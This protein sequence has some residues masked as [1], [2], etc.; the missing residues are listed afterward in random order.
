M[1]YKLIIYGNNM[2]KEFVL[3][4]HFKGALTFGTE[5]DCQICFQ[6]ERFL[7]DFFVQLE[8]KSDGRYWLNCSKSVC[9]KTKDGKSYYS[10]PADAGDRLSLCYMVNG[11]EFFFLDFVYAFELV[12]ADYNLAIDWS[13]SITMSVGGRNGCRVRI[14]D[15]NL[16]NDC[17]VIH[18]IDH[19]YQLDAS[20]TE[21]GISTN[22]IAIR[23]RRA[24]I[25]EGEFFSI[26]GY[27]FCLRDGILYTTK[28]AVITT[29]LPVSK[30]DNQKNYLNY[31]KFKRNVRQQYLLPDTKIEIRKPKSK[32]NSEEQNFL[33][34]FLPVLINFILMIGLRGIMGGGGVFVLY[35]AGSM[36]VS[37]TVS[38]ITYVRDKKK[39]RNAE[40]Q[41]E[42]KYLEYIDAQEQR[43]MEL[44]K[45]EK[46]IANQMHPQLD[47]Y[48]KF[49]ADFD[50]RLFEKEREHEDYLS[51]RLGSGVVPSCCQV[52]YTEEEYVET[53][54]ELTEYPRLL[55]D[56]YQYLDD[57]PVLLELKGTN[58]VG[59]IGA[60]TKLYQM[61]KNLLISYA[62]SHFYKDVKLFLIMEEEDVPMFEWARWLQNTYNDSTGTRNFMYDGESA[63]VS[64][65]FL[66]SELSSRESAG[67]VTG[68]PEYIVFVYRSDV[69]SEHPVSEYIDRAQEFG[70]HFVFFEEHE[71]LLHNACTKRIFLDSRD[72]AG[73]VQ[74]VK[75]GKEIQEFRYLHI[76]KEAA[77]AAA[78]RLACVYV[79]E[80][81]LENSL[82]KNITLFE[83][84]DILSPYD[85]DLHARW[86]S[87]K[88]YESMRAPLGVKSGGEIVYLDLHEKY[89]GPHGL[90][91]GTT[92]SGKSEIL[93]S[94]IL[95][96]ATLFPPSEVGFIIIDFK[97]GGMAN[98]FR[99]LPHLIGTITNIDGREI[100]RSLLSIKAELV[101]RQELF[102]EQNVNHIND[103]IQAYKEGKAEIALP[104][105]IL[106][107][108]EFAELKSDQPEFMKELISASRIGR[109]LG[110]HLI[111][112]T[113]K[114]AGVVSD[115]IWSNSKFKL[116]LKVQ[117]KN[118]SNEVL[119]SPLAAEIREPGR[120]YLQ[121]GNNEI[122]QLFQSAYSGARVKNDD[123]TKQRAFRITKV[124]LSGAR[125]VLYE[126]KPEED[127]QGDTQLSALVNY[128]HDY[129]EE[130]GIQKLPEICLPSL[131]D[132]LP[133][134]EEA[135]D[136]ETMEGVTD[137]V[138]PIGIVDV[139]DRQAQ[140]VET[141]DLSKNNYFI[142]G[143]SQSGKTNLLQVM[144]RGLAQSY[145]AHQVNMYIIDMA[146]MILR[147][148]DSLAHVAGVVTAG[149]ED[150]LKRLLSMLEEEISNR[151]RLLSEYGLSSYSAYRE[152]GKTDLPQIVVFLDNWNG[153]KNTFDSYV[154]AFTQLT[155]DSASVGIS[156]VV[157]ISQVSG[158]GYKLLSGFSERIALYCNDSSDY[159]MI[160]EGCR[161]K[162]D[163]LAGRGI[164]EQAKSYYECQFYLAF[165]AEKEIDRIH[166]IREF[167]A[168]INHQNQGCHA[169]RIPEIPQSVTE[170]FIRNQYFEEYGQ[171]YCIPIGIEY[172]SIDIRTIRM[173][174]MFSLGLVNASKEGNQAF[175]DYL[176]HRL[177]SENIYQVY[178]FDDDNQ[179]WSRYEDQVSAYAAGLGRIQD[180]LVQLETDMQARKMDRN[181]N[182]DAL[183]D[184]EQLVVWISTAGLAREMSADKD[185][186]AI[187]KRLYERCRG[188]NLCFIFADLDNERISLRS[189]DLL[190]MVQNEKNYLIYEDIGSI[191]IYD[192]PSMLKREY[193]K[194]LASN[195]AYLIRGDAVEKIKTME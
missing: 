67:N 93:Q 16:E 155:R 157:T 192:I 28:N 62:A 167:I 123:I 96:M 181:D 22:G 36:V 142:I 13:H 176:F 85:L 110:I 149:D 164:I 128:I 70:F 151:K 195:E 29:D 169:K 136:V 141:V 162:L 105:L 127:Q 7:T 82:T 165:A 75:D 66:Y 27:R 126:Q 135:S 100:D 26:K 12:G 52:E 34:T 187:Y 81:N 191:E 119:K 2:Y 9:V 73:Y 163:N 65:E 44:R 111:L 24:E 175:R 130:H 133:F 8:Q 35:F 74:D 182:T 63:K 23:N 104:H 3:D 106:I 25:H 185:I 77:E 146:S 184:M 6:R 55:H 145:T 177:I 156:C 186:S 89:H 153:F 166:L 102:A 47:E 121:V 76:A 30:L 5:K 99:N 33:L 1:D 61:E 43:L 95:S 125:S 97:G 39:R 50:S 17:V 59:F 86:S 92:G 64:L 90:V 101:K 134:P 32:D 118:D 170:E 129:C 88:I 158:A 103:Y 4:E 37:S 131:P 18:R 38:I 150:R 84:L 112:A 40:Q 194:P 11:A 174:Q 124:A 21:F 46:T 71:E 193:K 114:P 122:F 54:D 189:G 180:L 154:D 178:L 53:D 83:L 60:R 68:L 94:Y 115:Q 51:V 72:N 69:I 49:I 168:K 19:G 117:N 171:K 152:A 20:D 87:S 143:S 183:C 139:P 120:A 116:C 172:E 98:Q 48:M 140:Y 188:D 138:V 45:Q 42:T 132:I 160:F 179:A 41:R 144:I 80:V 56:K 113:Q 148:Y 79:D 10:C 147:N 109:S 91:A 137:I 15:L 190:R 173:N 58:A 108:D 57:M 159:N 14:E 107:V 31:P 78:R 161:L